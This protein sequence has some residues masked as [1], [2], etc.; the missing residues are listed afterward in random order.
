M[1]EKVK[2]KEDS[3]R[4]GTIVEKSFQKWTKTHTLN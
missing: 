2:E 4:D 1:D 3:K